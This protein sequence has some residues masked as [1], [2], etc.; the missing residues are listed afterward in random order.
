[1]SL[2][3]SGCETTTRGVTTAENKPIRVALYTSLNADCTS[4]GDSVVRIVGNPNNGSVQILKSLAYP[5]YRQENQR[6]V[7][8]TR[9]VS[10]TEVV[11]TPNNG[12]K[13]V[14]RVSTDVIYPGGTTISEGISINVK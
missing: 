5:N 13:G 9:K 11:Y 2:I 8:N 1:M 6:Y 3:V 10:A 4:S 12:F 14:D 7:C